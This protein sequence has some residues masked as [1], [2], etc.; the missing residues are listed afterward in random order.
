MFVFIVPHFVSICCLALDKC[1]NHPQPKGGLVHITGG[2]MAIGRQQIITV[3]SSH[4]VMV[5]GSWAPKAKALATYSQRRLMGPRSR[6]RTQ[7]QY[8][9][10]H[11][12][13]HSLCLLLTACWLLFA[14]VWLSHHMWQIFFKYFFRLAHLRRRAHLLYSMAWHHCSNLSS[15]WHRPFIQECAEW[16]CN[17]WRPHAD[18][19]PYQRK[20]FWS[21]S[22]KCEAY[23]KV[24][25]KITISANPV[26]NSA[27]FYFEFTIAF[28]HVFVCVLS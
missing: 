23:S 19:K 24:Q 2:T 16:L 28:I 7:L 17:G 21:W 14:S 25:P 26:L 22:F 12:Q 9:V 20:G 10:G 27:F 18:S 13:V 4:Q 6:K 15:S 3:G 8:R 11:T 5:T 1:N